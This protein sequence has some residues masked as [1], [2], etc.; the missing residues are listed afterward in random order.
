M[1]KAAGSLILVGSAQFVVGMVLA[2]ALYP[3]Y[4]VANNT[5]SAL[6]VGPSAIIFNSSIFLFGLMAVA[7]SYFIWRIFRGKFVTALIFIAGVG[8]MGVGAFPSSAGA[9][10]DVVSLMAFFF[11][12]LSAI[13]AY[14]LEKFPLNY[15]SVVMGLIALI[16]LVLFGSHN[17]LG[18]GRGGME[19][20]VAYPIVLWALGFGGYLIGLE[21]K[22]P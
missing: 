19:R 9:I 21:E 22:K 16:A 17:Y 1:K 2:E 14:R 15:I 18:L 6:G 10:H 3:G 11:G 8:A 4:S 12:G 13:V 5:I 7:G 20:M